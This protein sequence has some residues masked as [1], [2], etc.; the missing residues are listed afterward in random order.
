MRLLD[1]TERT[2]YPLCLSVNDYGSEL[3]LIIHSMQPADPQRLCAMMQCA[4]E[5]LTD[6]LAHTPQMAVTAAGCAA[7]RR[8]Q[9]AAGDLQP[10]PPGLP[11]GAV[12]SAPV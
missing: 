3:D 12:H 11:D 9:P 4:L 10:D 5:Q 7:R 2:N 6:A 1:G 8:A